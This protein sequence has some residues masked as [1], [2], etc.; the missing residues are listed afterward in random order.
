VQWRGPVTCCQ[1]SPR[2]KEQG[3]QLVYELR[4]HKSTSTRHARGAACRSLGD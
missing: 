4:A 1:C 2:S 3:E